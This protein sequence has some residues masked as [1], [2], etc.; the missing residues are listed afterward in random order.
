MFVCSTS[1]HIT[2]HD[3]HKNFLL[4]HRLFYFS[5]NFAELHKGTLLYKVNE[6]NRMILLN[7]WTNSCCANLDKITLGVCFRIILFS[8]FSLVMQNVFGLI[9]IPFFCYLT[10]FCIFWCSKDY[11][12]HWIRTVVVI[13]D[14]F[15]K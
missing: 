6:R 7:A 8:K 13:E 3:K 12:K 9:F 15:R 2:R 14:E 4:K 11:M 10:F 1:T 5:W